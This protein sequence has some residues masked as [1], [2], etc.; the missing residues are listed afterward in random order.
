VQDLAVFERFV[1]I[2]DEKQADGARS[3]GI[4]SRETRRKVQE[5]CGFGR[6]FFIVLG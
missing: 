6:Y 1:H 4:D 2:L 5:F 3:A